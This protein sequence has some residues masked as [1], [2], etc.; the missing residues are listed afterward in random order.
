MITF[1]LPIY[2]TIERKTKSSTTSLVG[3]NWLRNLHHHTK[4]T[5]KQYYHNLIKDLVSSIPSSPYQTFSLSM[6]LYYKNPAT[7][8]SNVFHAIEKFTLDG[9]QD[10]KVIQNDSVNHHISTITSIGGQ[11]KLNPRCEITVISKDTNE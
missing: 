3:D 1:S 11:D 4:N 5:V 9:L 10:I 2:Y 6:V 8:P 7:D